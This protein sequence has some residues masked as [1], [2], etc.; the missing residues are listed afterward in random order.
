M[1][2]IEIFFKESEFSDLLICVDNIPMEYVV[3]DNTIRI[4]TDIS[5][6]VHQLSVTMVQGQRLNITDVRADGASLRMMLYL[7][8]IEAQDKKL[9]PATVLWE[10][11]QVWR[12]PFG[13]PVSFWQCLVYDK[14]SDGEFGKN[15]YEQYH[16]YYPESIDVGPGFPE[17]IQTFFKNDFDFVCIDRNTARSQLPYCALEL[18]LDTNKLSNTVNEI[19]QKMSWIKSK[20]DIVS[21]SIYNSTE[22]DSTPAWMRL[23]LIREERTVHGPDDFPHLYNLV[24]SLRLADIKSMFIGI[25]PPGGCIAPHKDRIGPVN[26]ARYNNDKH[27]YLYIPLSWS[28]GN[29]FKING[30]GLLSDGKP[31]MINHMDYVHGLVNTSNQDRYILGVY[32]SVESN[33]HLIIKD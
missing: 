6:G 27:C 11:N 20:Q 16:I 24:D 4:D 23:P 8:Y 25:L 3:K 19:Q 30:A 32:A 31:Y 18:D 9:Q 26:S 7:S 33:Q 17:V 14:L 15:L 1:T 5:F 29:Y 22:F 10:S 28:L 21:Q 2:A 12:L 13:Y